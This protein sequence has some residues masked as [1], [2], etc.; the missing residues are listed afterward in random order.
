[1][2]N[3][4]MIVSIQGVYTRSINLLR[5]SDNLE[6]LQAYLPT[7][8]ALQTLEQFTQSLMLKAADDLYD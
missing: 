6:L 5:D 8:K 2:S 1:M 4:T 3:T 7:S